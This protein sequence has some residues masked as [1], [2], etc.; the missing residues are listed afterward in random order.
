MIIALCYRHLVSIFCL[1]SVLN[2]LFNT[3]PVLSAQNDILKSIV[4][5]ES[6]IPS[7]ARTAGFLGSKR[8]GSGVIIDN[9]GL[10]LTIGYLILEASTIKV[11]T[12]NGREQN[13]KLVAY[14]H[15]SGLGLI[16]IPNMVNLFSLSLGNSS[17]L[18]ENEKVIVA[19]HGIQSPIAITRVVSR[20]IFTGYWEYLLENAIFT[21]PPYSNHSGAALIGKSGKLLG[22]GSLL[23][24]DAAIQNVFLP[25]N[26][27]VPIDELKPILAD[28]LLDGRR[29]GPKRPW[30]GANTFEENGRVYVSRISK[31]GPASNAGLEAGDLIV[32]VNGIS[33]RNQI[34]FYRTLWK[35]GGPGQTIVLN[36]LPKSMRIPAIQALG[37]IAGDRSEWLRINRTY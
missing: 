2:L 32:G 10:V 28:L 5:I 18:L 26:M 31:N 23:V 27:F 20:R 15:E 21:S 33:I 35:A 24:N 6:E 29:T 11:T 36:I 9:E 12:N 8:V 7:D 25:G 30:I 17:K 22:I 14:D 13:A 1:A 4:R 34:D 19:A 37:I 16:R 3:T